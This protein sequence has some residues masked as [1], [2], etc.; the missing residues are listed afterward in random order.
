MSNYK[1]LEDALENALDEVFEG[2]S[3]NFKIGGVYKTKGDGFFYLNK[4]TG[5]KIT[6]R[7]IYIDDGDYDEDLVETTKE[8]LAGEL[9]DGICWVGRYSTDKG[10]YE[11]WDGVNKSTAQRLQ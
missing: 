10:L 9:L 4:M 7:F 2:D 8:Q 1:K 11:I 5:N 3:A 6:G